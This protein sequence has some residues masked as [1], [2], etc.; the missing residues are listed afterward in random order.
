[1]VCN[2]WFSTWFPYLLG[3]WNIEIDNSNVSDGWITNQQ[4]E[5]KNLLRRTAGFLS[6]LASSQLCSGAYFA[7]RA[8]VRFPISRRICGSFLGFFL[9]VRY[10]EIRKFTLCF[11]GSFAI[12]VLME[13]APFLN[14]CL[15]RHVPLLRFFLP[16][17][18]GFDNVHPGNV[19][20]AFSLNLITANYLKHGSPLSLLLTNLIKVRWSFLYWMSNLSN[21]K[22]W[23]HFC[24]IGFLL[25]STWLVPKIGGSYVTFDLPL[26]AGSRTP[27]SSSLDAFCSV[28]PSVWSR[29]SALWHSSSLFS[30]GPSCLLKQMSQNGWTWSKILGVITVVIAVTDVNR[31]P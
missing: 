7:D 29:A 15:G 19:A 18:M 26:A 16:R 9:L 30:C 22:M 2:W 14:I 1:M 21:Q 3:E 13:N 31:E 4:S 17:S 25:P 23:S 27:S 8:A 6:P 20:V 5:N 11:L 10:R 24:W 28:I 12:L